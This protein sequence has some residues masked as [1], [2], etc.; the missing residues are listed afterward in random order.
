[1]ISIKLLRQL[2]PGETNIRISKKFQMRYFL[3]PGTGEILT[4]MILPQRLMI[5]AIADHVIWHPQ[6]KLWKRA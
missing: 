1:M 4:A 2:I 3:K 6:S 5:K